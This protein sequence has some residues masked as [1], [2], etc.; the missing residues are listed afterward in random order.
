M[1]RV[2]EIGVC[3]TGFNWFSCTFRLLLA[4]LFGCLIG[5]GRSKKGSPVGIKT[6]ALVC[7]AS[8]LVMLT[9]EYSTIKY[10]SGDIARMPA[11]VISGIGFLGAGTILITGKNQ[12]KGL[13]SAAGIWFCACIGLA[14]GIGFYLAAGVAVFLEICILKIFGRDKFNLVNKN[15]YEIF[16]EYDETFMLGK[17]ISGV[18]EAGGEILAVDNS[19]FKAFENSESGIRHAVIAIKITNIEQINHILNL[20]EQSSGILQVSNI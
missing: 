12:I 17:L 7:I 6:H 14:I 11:Q 9:S 5:A 18:K 13:T 1:G 10:G 8:A 16:L 4:L 20:L 19:K 15:V 2:Y 3:L